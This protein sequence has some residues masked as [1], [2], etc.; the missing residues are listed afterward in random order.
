MILSRFAKNT[1]ARM[2]IYLTLLIG[3]MNVGSLCTGEEVIILDNRK[4]DTLLDWDKRALSEGSRWQVVHDAGD[5]VIKL[6]S[7]SS[8]LSLEKSI[9]VDLKQ[10]PYLEWE[11]KVTILPKEGTFTAAESDDQ[12]AQLLVTFSKS[13]FERRKVITYL[14]DSTAPKGTMAE[15]PAAPPFLNIKAVVVESGDSHMGKWVLEKRNLVEDFRMLFG[16]APEQVI[17]LRIQ[18]NS[19]HTQSDAEAF[20]KTIRFTSR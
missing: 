4:V 1:I 20:W 14:W 17:G 8:S 6:R 15:A 7:D 3:V 13:L 12:A 19:Q 2:P 18:I 16:T 10:T 9:L 11:W 5:Q